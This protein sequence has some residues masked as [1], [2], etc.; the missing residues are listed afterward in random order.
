MARGPRQEEPTRPTKNLAEAFA[1]LAHGGGVDERQHAR[2]IA[3]YHCVK[4]HFVG[5]LQFAQEGI[6][7]EIGVHPF[8]HLTPPHDLVFEREHIR[9][10]QA[11][12]PVMIALFER[13]RRAPVRQR[14]VEQGAGP[15]K[16]GRHHDSL[17]VP[18]PMPAMPWRY[19]VQG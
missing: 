14:I 13:E 11:M 12:Q 17:N 3:L 4:Q 10:Q 8:E 15:D 9:R 5:I 1:A 19:R 6:A 7:V 2:Q 16:V 18:L